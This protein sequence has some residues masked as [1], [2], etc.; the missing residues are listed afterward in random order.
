MRI[1]LQKVLCPVDFS[2]TSDHALRYAITFAENFGAELVLL[3]VMG[4]PV[5]PVCDYYGFPVPDPDLADGAAAT[6]TPQ[7]DA[8]EE[9]G[10]AADAVD[11]D[12]AN[13][14]PQ[15]AASPSQDYG[16]TELAETLRQNH[17]CAI[18]TQLSEGKAFLE[19]ITVAKEH[20]VDLIVMGTHGR[21]G[22]AHVLMGSTAEKV[23][24]MAPCPVLTVKHPEHEF[25]MP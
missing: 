16:L 13:A 15:P 2:T 11:E 5:A 24:R 14:E 12:D 25:V 10:L 17:T 8:L 9:V 3:H 21:T 4:T 6:S 23:V 20:A 1:E 19:I 7:E 18:R 22:L